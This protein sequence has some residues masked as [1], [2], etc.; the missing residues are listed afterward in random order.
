MTELEHVYFGYGFRNYILKDFSLKIREGDRVCLS[1]PSGKG[2]TTALR[3]ITGLEK[4]R[5]GTVKT[6]G[7]IKISAVFQDD[8]LLPWK[9]V[10]EN[11]AMFSSEEAAKEM[12]IKLGLGDVMNS[13]PKELSGG[14]KRRA[15]LARALC[16]DFDMLILDEPLT[17]LD[18]ENKANCLR[19]I[20][21]AL[22]GKTLVM[23]THDLTEA[24][25]LGA[26]IVYLP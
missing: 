6:D 18:E 9:T 15:A 26:R 12:L 14:M 2:K 11:T 19:L 24:E 8:R 20:N 7:D 4:P 5:R 21:E 23:A 1:A 3:L 13:L 10:L 16:H 25:Y 22:Q 17:G